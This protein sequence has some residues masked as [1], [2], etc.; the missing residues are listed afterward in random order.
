VQTAP[1]GKKFNPERRRVLM[2]RKIALV[3]TV[4][5]GLCLLSSC[6]MMGV[7]GSGVRKTDQR[8]VPAFTAVDSAGAYEIEIAVQKPVKV[9]LEGDDNILPMIQ[10]EVRNGVL[11]LH[12]D[13]P[14]NTTR[15][16]TV[17]IGVPSLE[18]VSNSGA[19]SIHITDVKGDKFAVHSSGAATVNVTGESKNLDISTSG[20][21]SIDAGGLRAQNA[22][23]SCSGVGNIDVNATDSLD[24]D[25]SGAGHVSYSG[26]PKITKNISGVGSVTKK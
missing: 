6:N 12:S 10:T 26:D 25:I 16:I 24:V 20:A 13:K 11:Y 2:M 14:F 7:R 15:A 22:K 9:E 8:T 5:L 23:V 18:S 1:Q 21:G 4:A 17:R 3:M 19:G